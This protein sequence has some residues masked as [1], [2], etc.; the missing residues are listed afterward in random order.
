MQLEVFG[1]MKAD[2]ITA[3]AIS[4]ALKKSAVMPV[5]LFCSNAT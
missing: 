1:S 4:L 5:I 2:D 3:R